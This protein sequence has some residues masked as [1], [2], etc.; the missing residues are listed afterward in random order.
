LARLGK[1][2]VTRQG[3]EAGYK[4]VEGDLRLDS[5]GCSRDRTQETKKKKRKNNIAAG[6]KTNRLVRLTA[7]YHIGL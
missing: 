6:A 7:Q 5:A 4:K 3:E 2:H 1:F